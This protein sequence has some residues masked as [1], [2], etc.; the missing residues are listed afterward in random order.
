M[1]VVMLVVVL[2][3]VVVDVVVG[4]RQMPFGR[5]PGGLLLTHNSPRQQ[6]AVV[7]HSTPAPLHGPAWV[8]AAP[9]M[10]ASA[11][12]NKMRPIQWFIGPPMSGPS[13]L[14]RAAVK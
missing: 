9:V 10:V 11:V 4:E 12:A 7:E 8:V 6:L 13:Q 5:F 1:A 14:S 3:V 2:L